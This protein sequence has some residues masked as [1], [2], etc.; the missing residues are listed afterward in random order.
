MINP[1]TAQAARP[2]GKSGHLNSRGRGRGRAN[3]AAVFGEEEVTL[4][5][6][7]NGRAQVY[8]A[9]KHQGNN[10]QFSV[11]QAPAS[12]EGKNFKL[13]IDSGSTHSFLSPKCIRNLSLEQQPSKKLT[14][15]LASGKELVTRL[16][17]GD[18]EFLLDNHPTKGYFHVMPLG[19]YNGI[20]GMDWLKA[21]HAI[22]CCHSGTISF[23]S[24]GNQVQ[25]DGTTGK[26]KATL[27]K[28]NKLLRGLRKNQQIYIAKLNKV[29]KEKP[30]WE[31]A[32]LQQYS[33]LFP[34]D[35]MQ[36]PPGRDIDHE[37]EL[38]PRATP[39]AKSPYKMSVPEA[40]EF[41]EQLRQLLEQG[42]I[43]PSV[44]PWGAPILF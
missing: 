12:Y 20:L 37:I 34:E 36:M 42:F 38:I 3:V 44:S 35:L 24:L 32:W 39:I 25:V 14:I 40:I 15:E 28:A 7:E 8:A 43:R 19:V 18:L 41:K 27:V 21:H 10:R 5:D 16:A 2:Y 23:I 26:P 33:D 4:Q 31:P 9:I 22:L 1:P 13:L 17:L 6:E 29:E 30:K 11:I